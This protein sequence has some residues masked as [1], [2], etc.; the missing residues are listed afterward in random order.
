MLRTCLPCVLAAFTVTSAF[1][2]EFRV[3]NAAEI[4]KL[5]AQLRPGDTVILANGAWKDQEVT[6]R[7]QGTEAQPITFRAESAG[8]VVISGQASV[9]IDG[10]HLIISGLALERGEAAKEGIA[11]R[12]QHCRVTEC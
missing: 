4:T 2:H 6:I 9:D 12:G 8:K 11:I 7:G 1:A 5:T 10:Q 3:S